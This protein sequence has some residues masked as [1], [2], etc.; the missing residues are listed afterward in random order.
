MPK[1]AVDY[2]NTIIYKIVC[3]D[4]NITDCYVGHTTNFIKRKYTHKFY[5]MNEDK[6][7][8][9]MS[10]YKMIRANGGW[11]NWSMVEVEKFNCNDGNE[12]RKKER[13]C[14]ENLNAKLNERVPS[15]NKKEWRDDNKEIIKEN[16]RQYHIKNRETI[17][18]K[19]KKHNEENSEHRKEYSRKYRLEHK[20]QEKLY[21]QA[22]KDEL[23]KKRRE[24]RAA[25]KLE[26][27][28]L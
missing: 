26:Q 13:E 10:V 8:S 14:L 22:N 2:S 17:I 9:N 18:A 7:D 27:Q 12:A 5:A 21:F 20:E 3:N 16:K 28:S 19:V 4:L 6:K 1:T 15:R 11:D 25:K 23:N 24:R